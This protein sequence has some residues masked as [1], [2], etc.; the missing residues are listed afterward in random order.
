MKRRTYK[1]MIIVT[2]LLI[3][4]LCYAWV[5]SLLG[6]GVPCLFRLA[7]GWQ[8]PGC[9]VSR[10]CMRLLNGDFSGAFAANP[11][12]LIILPALLAVLADATIR[13]IRKG[14]WRTEG[15]SSVLVY[16][17]IIVLLTFGVVRNL[18]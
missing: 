13:Y 15:W 8:C 7:T 14:I 10:M 5:C 17:L 11:V 6:F 18:I 2:A 3:G 9:G 16:I 4:G 12:L 1:V